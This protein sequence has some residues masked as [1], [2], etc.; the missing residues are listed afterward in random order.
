MKFTSTL[1]SLAALF[2]VASAD[3]VRY[4]QIYDDPTYSLNGVACSNG[5]HGLV[6]DGFDTLGDLPTFPGVGGVFAVSG[7]GSPECGSC[8]ELTYKGKSI[9]VTAVD[10]ISDGFDISLKAMNILTGG[11]A[12]ALDSI[13]AVATKVSRTHCGT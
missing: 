4:N 10:T 13:D 9:L 12:V 1:L 8:W 3:I 7:W 11:K 6:T 5:P 2:S